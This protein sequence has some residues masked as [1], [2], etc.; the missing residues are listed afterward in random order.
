MSSS[1]T[2]S[3]TRT[4]VAETQHLWQPV[5]PPPRNSSEVIRANFHA[6]MLLPGFSIAFHAATLKR[7]R[8]TIATYKGNA[9]QAVL[10][11]PMVRSLTLAQLSAMSAEDGRQMAKLRGR[12]QLP[13]YSLLA[14]YEFRDRGLSRRQIA[15]DF[16][17]SPGTVAHVL[18]FRNQSYEP[19]SGVRRMTS[20]QQRPPGQFVKQDEKF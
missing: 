5:R 3:S 17:C 14:I 6:Y 4:S 15:K 1:H 13:H 2:I 7:S 8:T 20:A 18:R 19:L 10:F 11:N 9:Q 16:R 12:A